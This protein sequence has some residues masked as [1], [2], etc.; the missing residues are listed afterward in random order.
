MRKYVVVIGVLYLYEVVNDTELRVGSNAN[1]A[2]KY[3]YRE[4]A[5]KVASFFGGEVHSCRE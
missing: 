4:L 2:L 1:Q 3:P 5:Q